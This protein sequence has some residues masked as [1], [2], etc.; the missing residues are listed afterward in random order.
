MPGFE[1]MWRHSKL[2]AWRKYETKPTITWELSPQLFSISDCKFLLYLI[3]LPKQVITFDGMSSGSTLAIPV[4]PALM[5]SL[6]RLV[7]TSWALL[8]FQ[9]T[10]LCC[11]CLSMIVLQDKFK[12]FNVGFYW[13]TSKTTTKSLGIRLFHDKSKFSKYL[14]SSMNS[15]ISSRLILLSYM[16]TRARDLN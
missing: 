5:A 10:G 4:F 12:D 6:L 1:A 9:S 14:D 15:A 16:L 2:L 13:I 7:S 11:K 3:S 8:K